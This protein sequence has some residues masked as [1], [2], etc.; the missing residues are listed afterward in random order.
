[1]L[2]EGGHYDNYI[3]QI[4]ECEWFH[5]WADEAIQQSLKGR[6][7]LPVRP[8]GI[9]VKWYKPLPGTPKAVISRLFFANGIWKYA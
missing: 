7:C 6:R 8:Y 9:R 3:V 5:F 2:L 4:R 1:M